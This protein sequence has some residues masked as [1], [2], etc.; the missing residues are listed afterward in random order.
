MNVHGYEVPQTVIDAVAVAMVGEFTASHLED[1]AIA[2]GAPKTVG[3]GFATEYCASRIVDRLIQRERK[4]GNIK[5][6]KKTWTVV[7]SSK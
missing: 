4:A 3:S 7:K 5:F 6:S 2:A 1:A